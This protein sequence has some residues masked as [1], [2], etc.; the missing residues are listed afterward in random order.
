MR[1]FSYK[2]KNDSGF[3]P[4]PFWGTLTLANCKPRIREKKRDGDWIAG[5][6]S[7]TLYSKDRVSQ[8]RLIY[9]AQICRKISFADYYRDPDFACKKPGKRTARE[10]CGDNIYRP[11]RP[12]AFL[13]RDFI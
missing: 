11:R 13:P 3:A 10:R 8:E 6:T 2:M 9:L 12:G 4:N 1:L 5:F 7:Q